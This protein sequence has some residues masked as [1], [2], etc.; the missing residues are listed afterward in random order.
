MAAKLM[1]T[2]W[3]N[4][5]AFSPGDLTRAGELVS[6]SN[7]WS[8]KPIA[9]RTTIVGNLSG[10]SLWQGAVQVP[11][12]TDSQFA[13]TVTEE[14]IAAGYDLW[15]LLGDDGLVKTGRKLKIFDASI[16]EG[17]A[18]GTTTFMWN[19]TRPAVSRW[20]AQRLYDYF[21]WSDGSHW[22]YWTGLEY[23]LL[24]T[25]PDIEALNPGIAN[26]YHS[27]GAA[28][29]W[30]LYQRGHARAAEHLR[31]LRTAAGKSTIILGQQFQSASAEWDREL[32]GRFIEEDPDRWGTNPWQTYHDAQIALTVARSIHGATAAAHAVEMRYPNAYSAGYKNDVMAWA[33]TNSC[34]VSWGR[35]SSAG[36][37]WPG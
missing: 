35:D 25:N 15:T 10:Y 28:A 7:R 22:D 30:A 21:G 36:V 6:C 26:I 20:F 8:A 23:L 5:E 32:T 9:G 31:R 14:G 11:G 4:P 16:G 1:I 19:M 24:D 34:Y 12:G 37:G 3:R 18:D 33:N 27:S 13:K 2:D 17:G 29:G